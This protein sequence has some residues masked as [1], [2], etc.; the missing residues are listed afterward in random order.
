MQLTLT[1]FLVSATLMPTGQGVLQIAQPLHEAALRRMRNRLRCWVMLSS[2]PSGQAYLHQK[3]GTNS[4]PKI[5][6][7]AIKYAGQAVA[8]LNSNSQPNPKM[9]RNGS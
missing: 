8:R 6:S 1:R 7:T 4:A 9:V 2:P 3:R 5:N